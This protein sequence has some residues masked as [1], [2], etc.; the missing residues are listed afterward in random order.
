[1]GARLVVK[2]M[3]STDPKVVCEEFGVS[4]RTLL[5]WRQ[6]AVTDARVAQL[7]AK[8]KVLE[9]E[10]FETGLIETARIYFQ[11]LQ[12][13]GREAFKISATDPAAFV[14]A[15]RQTTGTWQILHNA[16]TFRGLMNP[17]GKSVRDSQ[18]VPAVG[19]GAQHGARAPS[20]AGASGGT[21]SPTAAGSEPGQV[22]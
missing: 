18:Q 21:S 2:A 11:L 6:R 10:V 5:R 17:G 12:Y 8:A 14:K 20:G 15:W 7:V 3:F 13:Q 19:A 16:S 9:D 4:V 1:M 22:H